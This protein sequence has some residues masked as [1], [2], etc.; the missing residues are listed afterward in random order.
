MMSNERLLL[1]GG[2]LLRIDKPGS[3]ECVGDVLVEGSR[4]AAVEPQISVDTGACEILDVSGKIVCPGFVDTH[5]HLWQTPFRYLGADWLIAHYAKAMWG[6]AGPKYTPEDLYESV[7]LGLVDALNAGVTQVFDWNHNIISPEHADATVEAHRDSGARVIFGYGQGTPV[8]AEMLD[9][10]IGT[11][12]GLPSEDVRRVRTRYY[13]STDA[14]L[15]LALAARGPE[16]SPM[17]VVIA[18]AKQARELALRSSIHIGN[19]AWAHIRPVKLMYDA[20]LL[21]PDLTWVHCNTLSD[22]ELQYIAESG[23]K[24]SIAPEL[25]MHMGHGHPAVSRLM[26]V[27]VRPS[28]SVDTCTNVSGDLFAIMRATLSIARGDSNAAII[29]T[30]VMPTEVVLSAR[31][32]IEFATLQGAR[33]N[34]LEST[35]GSLAVGKQ[36]DIVVIDTNAPNLIP[37]NYG[38]GA[39][40]MGAHA[41]NVEAVLVAGRF[42]KRDGRLVDFATGQLRTIAERLRD[43]LFERIGAT[44]GQWFPPLA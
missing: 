43:S 18:E 42:V 14:L 6:M 29:E 27:G 11:S 8:W 35:T 34:G 44:V 36:A 7:K 22:A 4:I 2:T 30:G 28:L 12:K 26:K 33:A 16:V 38:A 31:D 39:T 41:G 15:T 25:E 17:E 3:Q 23:G 1:K 5:R 9:P 13:S 24:V 21:G 20:G 19:G 10:A 37:L 40:V 32:V